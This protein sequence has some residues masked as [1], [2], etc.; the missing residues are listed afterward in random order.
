MTDEDLKHN[1]DP[2]RE[3]QT[4][5]DAAPGVAIPIKKF[6]EV[7]HSDL[8]VPQGPQVQVTKSPPLENPVEHK[9]VKRD[10]GKSD[11]TQ[12]LTRSD[13]NQKK[14]AKT[15]QLPM[16]NK[17]SHAH[18]DAAASH[19]DSSKPDAPKTS[20]PLSAEAPSTHEHHNTS[21]EQS[22]HEAAEETQKSPAEQSKLETLNNP[23]NSHHSPAFVHPVPVSQ[24]VKN[25][26][27]V[28][29]THA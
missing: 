28:P 1:G 26:A 7:L 29:V 3:S 24:I 22:T 20:K 19:S 12:S 9:Q 11:Q 6:G 14:P 23:A 8:K 21:N 16:E 15:A 25:S 5:V 4:I 10:A 2:K 17:P 13:D 18:N 27:A